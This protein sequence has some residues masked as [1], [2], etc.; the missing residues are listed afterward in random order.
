MKTSRNYQRNILGIYNKYFQIVKSK[1]GYFY[2]FKDFLTNEYLQIFKS[3]K[4][5][6]FITK[7][8]LLL[9]AV[10]YHLICIPIMLISF[11]PYCYIEGGYNFVKDGVWAN[12][13]RFFNWVNI[14]I[15]FLLITYIVLR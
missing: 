8:F 6:R 13:V 3:K 12:G 9:I 11:Y 15:I 2:F 5:N 1:N 4:R 14:V 10:L 7:Y